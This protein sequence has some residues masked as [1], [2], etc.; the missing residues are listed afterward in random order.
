MLDIQRIEIAE[1]EKKSDG[2]RYTFRIRDGKHDLRSSLLLF[3]K[4][5]KYG[6]TGVSG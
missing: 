3:K 4:N 6:F 2:Y 5:G 1:V